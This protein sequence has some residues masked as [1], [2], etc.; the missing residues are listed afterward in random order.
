[1]M[2]R[3]GLKV[4]VIGMAAILLGAGCASPSSGEKEETKPPRLTEIE[5]SAAE[6][7]VTMGREAGAKLLKALQNGDFAATAGLPVGDAKDKL[8]PERFNA[9]VEKVVKANGGIQSFA[10]LTDL[11]TPPYKLLLWKVTFA[12]KKT[13]AEKKEEAGS[14][15]PET[16]ADMLFEL[17]MG[18]LDGEYKIVGFRFK[19]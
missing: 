1:M 7:V 4:G 15:A 17:W 2:I 18:K 13:E 12:P 6:S 11:N 19:I 8:T 10:Y 9:V 5:T 3:N 16:G 14:V